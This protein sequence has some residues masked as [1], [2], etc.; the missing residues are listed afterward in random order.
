MSWVT[1]V[2]SMAAS[3]S[4]T[5]AL[6]HGFI[7][8]RQRHA[9]V[10]LLFSLAALGTA[11]FAGFNLAV[12]DAESPARFASAMRWAHVPVWVIVLALSGFVRLYFRAGRMWLLW[13]ACGLRTVSL[14]LNFLTGQNLNYREIT[15]LRHISF[16]G[17]SVPIAVGVPNPWM[18][19]GQVSILAL[20]IFIL[21]ATI[22]VWRR[23]ERRLAVALGGSILLFAGAGAGQTALVSWGVVQWP[24]VPS[25]FYLGVIVAMGYELANDALRAAHLARDLRAREEELTLAAEAVGLGFWSWEFVRKEF[26]A[27]DEWRALFG[28]STPERLDLDSFL[29]RLHPDD[30]EITRQTLVK[31]DPNNDRYKTQYRVLLPD[32]RMRWIASQGRIEFNRNANAVRLRGVSVD[33]THVKQMDQEV[34]AH[35]NDVAHLLRV[36]S[37]GEFS[38]GLAHELKQP[39]TTILSSAQAAQLFLANDTYDLEEIRDILRDIVT[40][41]RRASDVINGLHL[42]LKKNEFQPAA[43]EANQLINDVLKLMNADLMARGVR[44][45]TK[46]AEHLPSIRGDHVQLQQVLINLILNASDAMS[47][48]A[49]DPRL[50]TLR[51]S[52]VEGSVQIS[53]A[54][55]GDGIP[56]GAEEKIFV[57][58]HTTKA[59]GLGLGLSLSRSIMHAHGGRLWAE[60]QPAGGA[61]F[62]FT[63]PEWKGKDDLKQP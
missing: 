28:F 36:A 49:D 47:R 32:G 55:T 39:L 19:V 53:V 24:L 9:W 5:L 8:W 31:R 13:T 48:L 18:L 30:R 4:L 33:I 20:V 1:V 56:P 38:S 11:A 43:L 12:M 14:F 60:N 35:R 2:F 3:A 23:G 59:Q 61:V 17:E 57:P 22:T 62:H 51:S 44:V 63:I 54:D 25:L 42:L 46:L 27:T 50:L 10:N 37:L 45:A 21:D 15:R 7:W 34:K 58:Y 40:A 6:I 16:L 26:W 29:Q 52:R 41:D